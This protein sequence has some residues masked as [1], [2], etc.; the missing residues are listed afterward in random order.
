MCHESVLDFVRQNISPADVAGREVLEVG[1]FD[2]N[3]SPRGIVEPMGPARYIGVDLA[4]GPGVDE[5]CDASTLE[6]LFGANSFDVVLSTEMLEHALDWRGAVWAMKSVLRPGGLLLLTTRSPGFGYHN[7]PD[8]WRFTVDD[9]RAI[10]DDLAELVVLDDPQVPGVLV[11]A[12][13]PENFV[14]S[15]LY[16]INP[17]VYLKEYQPRC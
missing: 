3:G 2:V 10:F 8:Y 5:V 15:N 11:R 1:S 4:P 9:A 6:L 16:Q 7:P 13:K 17:T 14:A 12:R